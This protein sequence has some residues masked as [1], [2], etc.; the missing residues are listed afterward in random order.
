MTA[1]P[2]GQAG[3]GQGPSVCLSATAHRLPAHRESRRHG[4]VWRRSQT[5]APTVPAHHLL[6]FHPAGYRVASWL[7]L[8][9]LDGSVFKIECVT[10]TPGV[11]QAVQLQ[12]V[13]L[14]GGLLLGETGLI[15]LL[16]SVEHV[17][18]RARTEIKILLLIKL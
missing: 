7:D 6:S 3:L 8:H 11:V 2:R 1:R 13:Q 9:G 12:L 10:Q 17:E 5:P 14:S 16:L 15:D 18:Q 4:S